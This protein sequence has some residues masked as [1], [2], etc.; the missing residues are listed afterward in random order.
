MTYTE[1]AQVFR[2]REPPGPND[3]KDFLPEDIMWPDLSPT[4]KL[5]ALQWAALEGH[6]EIVNYLIN[7]NA[8]LKFTVDCR[9]LPFHLA[10]RRGHHPV[11]FLFLANGIDVNHYGTS[12]RT[13]LYLAAEA[14]L[15][16]TCQLLLDNGANVFARTLTGETPLFAACENGDPQ[17]TRLFL[18]RGSWT[19][20]RAGPRQLTLYHAAAA[21][22]F[23]VEDQ[24]EHIET[25]K[26]LLENGT[27]IDEPDD[28]KTAIQRAEMKGYTDIARFL[29]EWRQQHPPPKKKRK[30]AH[31]LE[32]KI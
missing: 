13:A 24:P 27:D 12:G 25:L 23:E 2:Y 6:T 14:R 15:F 1:A 10:A 9:Y 4:S 30:P 5:T 18:D 17:L 16:H 7:R 19:W 11:I 32:M 31:A 28:G 29:E 21:G 3:P 20:I 8:N 26:I 22:R